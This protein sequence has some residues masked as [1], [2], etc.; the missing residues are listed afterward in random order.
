MKENLSLLSKIVVVASIAILSARCNRSFQ[1]GGPNLSLHDAA[2]HYPERIQE[3][4]G[5]G[6]VV[7][8]TDHTFGTPLMAAVR[9]GRTESVKI[10]LS[11]GAN[12]NIPDKLGHLPLP[13]AARNERMK[14]IVKLLVK[15]GAGVNAKGYYGRSALHYAAIHGDVAQAS[16]LF[17]KGADLDIRGDVF[18][19]SP[20]LCAVN[21]QNTEMVSFLLQK[22]ASLEV[23]SDSGLAAL[24]IAR[25]KDPDIVRLLKPHVDN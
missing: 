1:P 8:N 14:E 2:I 16:F 7:N 5:K 15:R 21:A 10:L 25:H 6:H 4:I 12:P 23:T 20:L 13:F 18:G 9:F 11:H 19:F 17:D 24:D 22:G 3:L